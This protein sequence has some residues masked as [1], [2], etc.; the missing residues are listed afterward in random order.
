[1]IGKEAANNVYSGSG[2]KLAHTHIYE[3]EVSGKTFRDNYLSTH[4]PKT[5]LIYGT[6]FT[7]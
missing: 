7:R 5:D 3:R 6:D 4:K 2:I 1:M